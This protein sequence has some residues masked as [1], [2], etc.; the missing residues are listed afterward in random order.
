[1]KQWIIVGSL[2]T[3]LFAAIACSSKEPDSDKTSGGEKI[4]E[5]AKDTANAV[6]EAAE[7][8]AD[9]VDEAADDATH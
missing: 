3:S 6:D 8:T 2:V 1:M 7:D 5:G 4:K 9:A